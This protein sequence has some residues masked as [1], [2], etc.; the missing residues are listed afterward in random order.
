MRSKI[1]THMS[2]RKRWESACMAVTHTRQEYLLYGQ[3][4]LKKVYTPRNNTLPSVTPYTVDEW[5][6]WLELQLALCIW[7]SDFKCLNNFFFFSILDER[8]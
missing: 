8:A 7:N 2:E 3:Q 1:Q 6:E 4:H 5:R